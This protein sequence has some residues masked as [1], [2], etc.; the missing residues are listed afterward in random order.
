MSRLTKE[1][2]V[3]AL[4]VGISASTSGELLAQEPDVPSSEEKPPAKEPPS[5][6]ED[7]APANEAPSEDEKDEKV[8]GDVDGKE[9]ITPDVGA[10]D[11]EEEED[12]IGDVD[13]VVIEYAPSPDMEEDSVKDAEGKEIEEAST[14]VVSKSVEVQDPDALE[15]GADKKTGVQGQVVSRKPKKVLPDAPVLAKGKED[16]KLRSTITDERGRYRLY[17][18]PGKYTLRSYYDLYHGARWDDIAVTRGK[19]SRVNFILDPISEKDAGVEEQ[20]VVYLADTSSEAAQLNIRKETVSVQDAISAEEISRAGDSTASGAVKRVVGV[21]IDDDGRVIIRGLGGKY[22]R[23]LLNGIPIPGV[24]PDVPS[25]KLD[26]FPA[27]IVSN[28]AV[29]KTPVPDLPGNFAGGLLLI[30]TSSFPQD[31]LLKAGVSIGANTLSTFQEM[32]TY[33]GG[34]R[35][36]LG[37]DDGTRALPNQVGPQFLGIDRSGVG[38][39]RYQSFDQI[40]NVDRAFEPVWNARTKR[41]IPK[42]GAK[43]SLGDSGDFKKEGRRGGYLLSFTYEYEEVVRDGFNRQYNFDEDGQSTIPREDFDF[44]Q[45]TQEVLWGVF[46][47]G[48]VEFDRD[49]TL[50]LT[51]FFSRTA[52]DETLVKL[53]G[54]EGEISFAPQTRTS[55]DFIGRTMFFNQLQGDHRN[56]GKTKLR[57]RWN[58]VAALGKRDQPDRRFVQQFLETQ[59]VPTAT[60]SYFDLNQVSAGGTTDLR[61]PLWK[62]FEGTAYGTVGF[63]AGF[64]KRDFVARRF[65]IAPFPGASIPVGDPESLFGPEGLGTLTLLSEITTRND[66]YRADNTL[67]GGYLQLETP[68][69]TWLK[70]LGLLRMEVFRQQVENEDPF[71]D[72]PAR[73]PPPPDF[74]RQNTDR[75]DIDPMPSANFAFT[76]N[77]KMFVKVGYGMTVIRPA[78]REL[79]PYPY[80]DFLRGWFTIGNPALQRSRVQ[81]VEARYEYYFGESNLVSATAFYKNFKDPIEFIITSPVN[82]TATFRN[83]EKAWLVGGEVELRVGLGTLSEKLDRLYFLGNV[84]VMKSKTTL[85]ADAAGSGRTERPLFGQSPYVTNLSLRF[86]DPDAGVMVGLVYNAFGRR[87]VEVGGA[88]GD[89]IFPDVYE[90]A[91]HL[92]DLIVTWKPTDH[93]KLGFKWK[94]IAF[95]KKQYEQGN[96]LVLVA[97]RGTSFSIGAEYIY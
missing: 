81:N 90:K 53:G 48:F 11:E 3:L 27:D 85:S 62:A 93:V 38:D 20:E 94:N 32:P 34:G 43:I 21:T 80:I 17:L 1:G 63:D 89:I 55:L 46:G 66:G 64:Q 72:D 33:D 37:F 86:D 8:R 22:N 54:A 19:L 49:N 39:G 25:V 44:K 58:G 23:T 76:I 96:Q 50:N 77:P 2:L 12:E 9:W 15:P 45:G 91:Q 73:G 31:F 28:L 65:A 7:K 6:E 18:P 71:A 30:E 78:I 24:D 57:L 5:D 69:T 35:D 82:R 95:A 42:L 14:P 97:N 74:V 79:A 52:A 4:L 29:V 75:R 92:L 13:E 68:M 40:A 61:F 56:L 87:I 47:S 16:G 36:W 70:F 51:S 26:I 59:R 60:R 10:S 41:A 84:A 88:A 83:A 67:L